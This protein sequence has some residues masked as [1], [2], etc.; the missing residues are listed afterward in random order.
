MK[1]VPGAEIARRRAAGEDVSTVDRVPLLMFFGDTSASAVESAVRAESGKYPQA[2]VL[3][4]TWLDR[5]TTIDEEDDSH[6][7]WE[8][9]EPIIRS[10]PVGS[11]TWILIHFSRR[12][13][14]Q[15]VR[16]FFAARLTGLPNVVIWLHSGPVSIQK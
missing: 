14:D 10:V 3:E 12:Y 7:S 16:E 2:I 5:P 6:C 1:G 15:Q 11:T 13:S 4:C 8:S 9:I